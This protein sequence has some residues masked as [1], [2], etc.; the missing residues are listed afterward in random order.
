[1]GK[2]GYTWYPK[3]FISDPVVMMMTAAERGVF[4]DLMDLAYMHDNIIRYSI[5]QLS[6]YC[7]CME[8]EISH[9]LKAKG[10]RM[11]DYWTIPSCQKRIDLIKKN[12]V[13][14]MKGGR[15]KKPK[16]NPLHNPEKTHCIRQKEIQSK[17]EDITLIP[18]YEVFKEYAFAQNLR[19]DY[20]LLKL[21]Y[22]SWLENDWKDGN[23]RPIKNWKS[24]LLN[25]LQ[26]LKKQQTSLKDKL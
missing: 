23:D 3:D 12:T 25:T 13:N 19:T 22:D 11:D 6:V 16:Q 24:K 21:K 9:V 14:G 2:L 5:K 4:R 15:P 7:N 26:Y 8:E 17:D 20:T 1:M 10:N 18:T